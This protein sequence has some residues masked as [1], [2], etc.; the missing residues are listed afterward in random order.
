M[1]SE[2]TQPYTYTD[3]FSPSRPSHP[4]CHT[5]KGSLGHVTQFYINQ[6]FSHW[7]VHMDH[8]NT[9]FSGYS[10]YLLLGSRSSQTQ[11]PTIAIRWIIIYFAHKPALWVGI[12]CFHAC[13]YGKVGHWSGSRNHLK[14]YTQSGGGWML[15][16]AWYPSLG[17]WPEAH[18]SPFHLEAW[19]PYSM[20]AGFYYYQVSQ[21]HK[22]EE[23]GLTSEVTERHFCQTL[24]VEIVLMIFPGL[25]ARDITHITW[26][27]VNRR[28]TSPL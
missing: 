19:P 5:E 21:W 7:D 12:A 4:G 26:W 14:T 2:G 6:H 1:D 16:V 8:W 23:H 24:L 17:A 22:A 15:A 18:T 13:L 28:S 27:E 3:P 9:R 10:G 25:R 11:R 20:V